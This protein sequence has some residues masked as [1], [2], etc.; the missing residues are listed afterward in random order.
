MNKAINPDEHSG[1]TNYETF[2]VA[3]FVD[4]NRPPYD[5]VKELA[6]VAM[7]EEYPGVWLSD[8]LEELVQET[9]LQ[10]E[11]RE[12]G[13]RSDTDYLAYTLLKAALD[14]VNWRELAD[15]WLDTVKEATG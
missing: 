2:T 8:Q 9:Y 13:N 15:T 6:A 7:A 11:R 10:M 3:L 4:N 12:E 5:Q 1:W 14:R